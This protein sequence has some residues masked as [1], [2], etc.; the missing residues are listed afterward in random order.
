M[1]FLK[2]TAALPLHLT[3]PGELRGGH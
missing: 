2:T 3:D 1:P